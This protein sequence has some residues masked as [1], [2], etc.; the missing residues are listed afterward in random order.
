MTIPTAADLIDPT[1]STQKVRRNIM[2][3]SLVCL[4]SA[5]IIADLHTTGGSLIAAPFFYLPIDST[6]TF[7]FSYIFI[8]HSV[9][10]ITFLILF[11][12]I[13]CLRS[14]FDLVLHQLPSTPPQMGARYSYFAL[15]RLLTEL[16]SYLTTYL[17]QQYKK[18]G[19]TISKKNLSGYQKWIFT[20][21]PTSQIMLP[22]YSIGKSWE[23]PHIT[24]HRHLSQLFFDKNSSEVDQFAHQV[25]SQ[26]EKEIDVTSTLRRSKKSMFTSY[27]HMISSNP[28]PNLALED[29]NST[30]NQMLLELTGELLDEVSLYK[31]K[32]ITELYHNAMSLFSAFVPPITGMLAAC[33]SLRLVAT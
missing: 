25:I 31:T 3:L 13:L 6:L 27:M 24:L 33:Y 12:T 22:Q 21:M 26:L 20:L 4:T 19:L 5:R 16:E 10:L 14:I 11:L 28:L 7:W 9:P 15:I 32:A 30:I 18:A 17:D 23:N 29:P 2:L 1:K 8:Y